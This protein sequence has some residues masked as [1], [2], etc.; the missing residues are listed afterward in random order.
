M[1]K[2]GVTDDW[3][4]L[5]HSRSSATSYTADGASGN[6][7]DLLARPITGLPDPTLLC[8][9]HK[10]NLILFYE[11][12]YLVARVIK[13]S[14]LPCVTSPTFTHHADTQ[15]FQGENVTVQINAGQVARGCWHCSSC[16]SSL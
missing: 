9:M 10:E 1:L 6:P 8:A 7:L 14:P 12:S 15:C 11:P 5:A 2:R 13:N 4:G 16:C 3:A